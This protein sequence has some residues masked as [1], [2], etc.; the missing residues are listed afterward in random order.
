MMTTLPFC[1]RP[2]PASRSELVTHNQ[3]V[4][5]SVLGLSKTAT[6]RLHSPARLLLEGTT[7]R[8]VVG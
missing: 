5:Y 7:G 6:V 4:H 1:K 8:C 3:T 2:L